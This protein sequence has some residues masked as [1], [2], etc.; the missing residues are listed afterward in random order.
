M[1]KRYLGRNSLVEMG[2]VEVSRV[3]RR[4]YYRLTPKGFEISKELELY[5][6]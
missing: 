6:I 2:L 4:K 5:R 3:G 1:P